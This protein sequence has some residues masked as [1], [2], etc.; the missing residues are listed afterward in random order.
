MDTDVLIIGGGSAGSM[1]AIRLK[2]LNRD[3]KVTIFEKANIKYS[4]SIP[5]GM[6]LSLGSI[7]PRI[8]SRRKISPAMACLTKPP[9]LSWLSAVGI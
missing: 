2:E 6:S 9:V 4:G 7:R 8:M 1:A 5:R 3:Q